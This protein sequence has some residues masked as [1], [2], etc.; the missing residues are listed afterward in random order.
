M[1]GICSSQL[2][3]ILTKKPSV[4]QAFLVAMP[5]MTHLQFMISKDLYDPSVWAAITQSSVELPPVEGQ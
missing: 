3:R 2:F 5:D 1:R 4:H